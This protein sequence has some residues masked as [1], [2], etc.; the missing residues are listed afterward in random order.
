MNKKKQK[1][2]Y[3]SDEAFAELMESGEQ[4]LRYERGE[5]NDLRVTRV[6]VP[7]PRSR[8]PAPRS[9]ACGSG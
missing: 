5:R 3:M 6:A 4:A 2:E 7:R 8:C 9:R 1:K